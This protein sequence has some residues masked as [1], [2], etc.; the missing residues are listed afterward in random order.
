MFFVHFEVP[1]SQL[2]LVY[3]A[4]YFLDLLLKK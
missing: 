2:H 1:A 4:Y 3:M